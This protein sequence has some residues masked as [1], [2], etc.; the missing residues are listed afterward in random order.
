MVEIVEQAPS[1]ELYA[2]P[3]HPYTR[4]LMNAFPP[5]SG[6][7]TRREGIAGRPPDLGT[8]IVGCP[9]APRC[10]RAMAGLCEVVPPVRLEVAP[11][12]VVACHLYDLSF[13]K[14]RTETHATTH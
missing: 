1:K 3:L 10:D 11:D 4:R 12:H 7:R 9:F 13:M 5:L 6:E 2:N 14:G 8:A